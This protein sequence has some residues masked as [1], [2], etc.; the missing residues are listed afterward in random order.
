MWGFKRGNPILEDL[1]FV[2]QLN[3][4][5]NNLENIYD[6]QILNLLLLEVLNTSTRSHPCLTTNGTGFI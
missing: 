3:G 5:V 2:N 4:P 1:K 6:S